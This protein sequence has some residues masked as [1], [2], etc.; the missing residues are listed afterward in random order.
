M[1]E[2]QL[3]AKFQE[4]VDNAIEMYP[5][6]NDGTEAICDLYQ[7]WIENLHYIK[8]AFWHGTGEQAE[9]IDCYDGPPSQVQI[10]GSGNSQVIK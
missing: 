2:E 8:W 4:L 1:T 5:H 7:F 3:R 6:G 9:I 10:G